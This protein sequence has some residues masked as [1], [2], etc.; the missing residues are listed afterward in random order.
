[1]GTREADDDELSEAPHGS[2]K[3]L[4]SPHYD[5]II[6][7][8]EYPTTLFKRDRWGQFIWRSPDL[9]AWEMTKFYLIGTL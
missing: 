8:L 1:M 9:L 3:V 5:Q 4:Y 6:L 7:E 2:V